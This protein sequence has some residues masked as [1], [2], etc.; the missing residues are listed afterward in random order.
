[1][2]RHEPDTIDT[3]TTDHD[4]GTS[5]ARRSGTP[6]G[7]ACPRCG[8]HHFVLLYVRQH[9]NRTVRR[10]ECRHCGRK[11]TTTERITSE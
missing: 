2:M 10:R 1:M 11:V 9:V 7:F 8:C 3:E 5:N 4:E 6:K